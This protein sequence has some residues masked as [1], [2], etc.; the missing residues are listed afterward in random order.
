MP[1]KSGAAM[2]AC[3]VGMRVV[4]GAREGGEAGRGGKGEDEGGDLEAGSMAFS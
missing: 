1:V 4:A 2:P 3:E